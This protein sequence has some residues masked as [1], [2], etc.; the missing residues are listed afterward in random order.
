VEAQIGFDE[1]LLGRE[2]VLHCRDLVLQPPELRLRPPRRGERGRLAFDESPHLEQLRIAA[3]FERDEQVER[4]VERV[5]QT[6]DRERAVAVR[7]DQALRFEHPQCL[8]NGRAA[9][10]IC[11]DELALWRQ[12]VAWLQAALPDLLDQPLRHELVRLAPV[13]RRVH[14]RVVRQADRD[15]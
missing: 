2:P 6:R 8:A 3:L 12:Y 11:T 14:G 15:L 13:D 5:A 9:D 1:A 7:R 4:L 10:A